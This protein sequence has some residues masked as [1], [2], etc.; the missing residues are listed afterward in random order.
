MDEQQRSRPGPKPAPVPAGSKML[1]AR[2]GLAQDEYA[3]A[4]RIEQEKLRHR[5]E[6][7]R[8]ARSADAP[9]SELVRVT[10]M[11]RSRVYQ[12]LRAAKP[13]R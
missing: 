10:K 13:K 1:L 6:L 7:L 9:V 8:A 12:I 5:D 11:D 2:L 3:E 4:Q